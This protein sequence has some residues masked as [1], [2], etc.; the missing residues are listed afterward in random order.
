[1]ED[2][3]IIG[4]IVIFVVLGI[5][6]LPLIETQEPYAVLEPY[7][8][9]SYT[10]VEIYKHYF[11]YRVIDTKLEES[12]DVN[13]GVLHIMS[14]SVLNR[15]IDGEQFLVELRLYDKDGLFRRKIVRNYVGAGLITTFSA[16]FDTEEDQ[17]VRGEYTVY[18]PQFEEQRSVNKTRTA[19]RLVTKYNTIKKSHIALWFGI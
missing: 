9:E 19:Y 13:R 15:H 8:K 4:F 12:Y 1:M 17:Y 10:I 6:I 16:E 3:S 18:P 2:K 14:I 7:K 5:L 11:I